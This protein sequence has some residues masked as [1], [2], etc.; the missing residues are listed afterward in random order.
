MAPVTADRAAGDPSHFTMPASSYTSFIAS[1][2]RLR[3]WT[4]E[5]NVN[6]RDVEEEATLSVPAKSLSDTQFSCLTSFLKP[7]YVKLNRTTH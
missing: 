2:C 1:R 3:Q 5:T 7:G 4:S 6:A